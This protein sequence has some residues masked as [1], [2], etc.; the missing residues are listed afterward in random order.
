MR[1]GDLLAASAQAAPGAPLVL[2]GSATATYGEVEAASDRLSRLLAASGVRRGDRVGLLLGNSARYVAAYFGVLKAGA[3]AVPMHTGQVPR[4]LAGTLADCGAVA[5]VAGSGPSAEAACRAAPEVPTLRA[6]LLP[7]RVEAAFPA[8]VTVLEDADA[9]AMPAGPAPVRGIDLDPAVIVYTS[10]STGRPRGAVLTHLNVVANT[11][12]IVDYLGLTASD[13]VVVVLPFPYVYGASL[14]HTHV[15]AGGSLVLHDSIVFPNTVLDAIEGHRATG[16]AGVPSTFA[17]LL[18]R[19]N[20]ASRSLPSLRYVTQAGGRMPPAHVRMLV[21][22][23]PGTRV[24]VMYGA[25]EAS[26]RLTWLPPERLADKLGSI[27]VPIPNV[28]LRVLREDGSEA[29]PDEV[30]EIVARGSNVM[31]GYWGDAEA[32]AEVLD[33]QGFHTGDL[34]RR[35]PDGFFWVVG[36]KREMIKAGAHRISP[37]EIEDVLLEDPSVEEAAVVGRPDEIL[38]EV[39]VAH[40]TA[41]PGAAPS[42]EALRAACQERL[43]AHKVPQEIHVRATMPRNASGKVDKL[44]LRAGAAAAER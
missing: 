17:I 2:H 33:A 7:S 32:T 5:L 38:G 23:L 35:D 25:T 4:S 31:Q 41:R 13:R 28:D 8:G 44:A 40:V 22:A 1:L 10:G 36:R 9:A 18:H 30:G 12:S 16:F 15:A 39:V 21:D 29:G 24:I 42:P 11:R 27:G 26:A 43:P 37:R 19:S 6:V 14:L 20:L 3:V 34:G